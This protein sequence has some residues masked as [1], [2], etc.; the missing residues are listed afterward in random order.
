MTLGLR[1]GK[2]REIKKI[3][4]HLGLAVNRLIRV[5]FGPFE[6]G[7][8]AE[9][10]VAEVRTRV[11]RDQLGIKL[12]KEANANFDAPLVDRDEPAREPRQAERPRG[13]RARAGQ[14]RSDRAA[15]AG[16]SRFDRDGAPRRGPLK[17]STPER[18]RK[19]VS[20]LRTEIAADAA[21]AKAPRRRLER[22][23]TQDRKGRTVKVERRSRAHDDAGGR[24]GREP[25]ERGRRPSSFES[26]AAR[27]GKGRERIG[28][29]HRNG[30]APRGALKPKGE[31]DRGPKGREGVDRKGHRSGPRDS[32]R[33]EGGDAW[34]SERSPRPDFKPRGPRPR[35]DDGTRP[36][37]SRAGPSRGK[38]PPPDRG[39]RR[40]PRKR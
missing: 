7:D 37:P 34:R 26:K 25:P 16:T 1:E 28:E 40:P 39:P 29:G 21:D 14:G 8:L 22:G 4:E 19:H 32:A 12:A 20:A 6:L 38:G 2:N 15:S 13:E 27:D 23:A 35:Q 17:P 9:G 11:L 18:R 33:R 31:R 36:K 3:L 5:S 10:E 30:S 24:P